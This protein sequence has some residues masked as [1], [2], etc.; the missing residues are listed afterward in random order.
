MIYLA[1]LSPGVDAILFAKQRCRQARSAVIAR[2]LERLPEIRDGLVLDGCAGWSAA[3]SG[4]RRF[5]ARFSAPSLSCARLTIDPH[6]KSP[7]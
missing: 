5:K 1:R 3:A 6:R 4:K 7:V 2:S